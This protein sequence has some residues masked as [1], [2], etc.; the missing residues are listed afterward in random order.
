MCRSW[1]NGK[2][3]VRNTAKYKESASPEA[4]YQ[5]LSLTLF[6][7]ANLFDYFLVNQIP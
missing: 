4:E 1:R 5:T 7:I 3:G 6:V 2:L